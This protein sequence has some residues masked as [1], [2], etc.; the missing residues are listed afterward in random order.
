[1]DEAGRVI[2]EYK[3]LGMTLR[4]SDERAAPE[5]C[6]DGGV[7]SATIRWERAVEH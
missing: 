6:V 1:M 4:Q 2:G 3:S 7:V 5:H